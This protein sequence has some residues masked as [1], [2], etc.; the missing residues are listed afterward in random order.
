WIKI[1]V[2]DTGAGISK[3]QQ[4]NLFSNFAQA[5][6]SIAAQFGDSGLG[7]SL[8]QNLCRLMGGLITVESDVG[9][10]SCFTIHL[11]AGAAAAYDAGALRQDAAADQRERSKGYSGLAQPAAGSGKMEKI[12]LVDDDRA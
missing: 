9:K 10:G 12:L 1:A 6:A 8:S 2:T 4:A 7:L 5:N 11:P 3:E